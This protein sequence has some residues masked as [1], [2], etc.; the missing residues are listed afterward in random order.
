MSPNTTFF[1]GNNKPSTKAV[2]TIPGDPGLRD[3]LV[4]IENG[5]PALAV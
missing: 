5:L 4:D 2:E 1:V 3:L